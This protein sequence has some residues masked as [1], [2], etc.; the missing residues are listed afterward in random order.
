MKKIVS[1]F[2]V[3]L[4]AISLFAGCKK[5]DTTENN[6]STDVENTN[7]EQTKEVTVKDVLNNVNARKAISMAIEKSYITDGILGGGIPTDYFVPVGLASD[8]EG[9]DFRAAYPDG[10]NKY[11]V[12]EALEYWNTAKEELGFEEIEIELLTY[13]SESSRKT[14]EYIQGQLETNLPGLTITLNQQPFENKL[15]LADQG[16][17]DFQFAGWGPDY[18]DPMTF[19]D[20]WVSG[21]GHNDAGYENPE[22]DEVISSAKSGDLALDFDARWK[23]LQEAEKTLIGDDAVLVPLYQRSLNHVQQPYLN[24]IY[25]HSFGGDFTFKRATTDRE[26]NF[27]YMTDSSDIPSMDVSVATDAVSFTAAANV[28]EGL[29]MLTENDVVEPG[30]AESWEVSEDGLTYTFHLR[31]NAVWSNGEPVTANDF[32]YSI[33]RLATPETASQYN[34]MVETAG[35]VNAAEV[36]S[37]DKSPEELGVTALDDYTLEFKLSTPVPYFVKLMTFPSFYPINEAFATEMGDTFGTTVDT[38]LYNGPFVLSKWEIGYEYEYAKNDTYWDAANTTL[39]GVNFRIVKDTN[40]AVNLY[41][42]GEIDWI[43]A[44]DADNLER[45]IDDPNLQ[46]W[47]QTVCFYLV[48]NLNNEGQY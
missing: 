18:P 25:L 32:V 3:M 22:Y 21:G 17:F 31:D 26:D 44:L 24:N 41:D 19:L 38:T 34:F 46:T 1:L 7:V 47:N 10:W 48:F 39:D 29:V 28:M 45:F 12:D 40:T 36:I 8:S 9:N 20:M 37:G 13:D 35:I 16:Q 33:R 6:N 5:E 14:S 27:I 2:F 4:I 42:T 11:N 15:E 30:V 23:A 43:R